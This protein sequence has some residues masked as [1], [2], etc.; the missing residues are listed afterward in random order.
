MFVV[1][2]LWAV[3]PSHCLPVHFDSAVIAA[4]ETRMWQAYYRGDKQVLFDELT[5]L[6]Q[7]QFGL[8]G[9]TAKR[10]GFDLA[11][12]AKTFASAPGGDYEEMILPDLEKAYAR[13]KDATGGDFDANEAA[14]AELDWWVARRTPGQNSVEEVGRRIARLYAILYGQTNEHIERAG[15]LRAQAARVRDQSSDWPRVRQLL[16]ESYSTLLKGI[17]GAEDTEVNTGRPR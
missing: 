10:V 13:I 14:R 16:E 5:T 7:D 4:A 9:W 15:Y 1:A 11:S 17:E 6:M 8:S 3:W 12:G 2:A